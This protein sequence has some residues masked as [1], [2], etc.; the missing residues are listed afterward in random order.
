VRVLASDDDAK[1]I[2]DMEDSPAD[3][4]AGR[5]GVPHLRRLWSRATASDRQGRAV[6]AAEW[7]VDLAVIYGLGLGLHETLVFLHSNAPSFASFEDW[8]LDRIGGV[9]DGE[10]IAW[11]NAVVARAGSEAASVAGFSADFEPVFDE[12]DLRC[13]DENGY[14][15]LHDAVPPEACRDAAR[16]IWD[17][18]GMDPDRPESWYD[19]GK[20]EG[21]MV[22]LV[23]HPALEKNRRSPR[24]RNAYA[25]LSGTGDLLVTMDRA[26]FNPPEK[27]DW[28]FPGAGL[29]WDTSLVL[30]MPMYL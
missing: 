16:A 22:P 28:R 20:C 23:H 12:C 25:Q 1:A 15:V 19:M 2:G 8:I 11:I 4:C 26:G 24:I 9:I 5:L 10:Q 14:V 27:I 17:F 30:P 6:D 21:L 13:W 7:A 18:T 3:I 29:H